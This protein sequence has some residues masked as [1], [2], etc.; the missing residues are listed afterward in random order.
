MK[1]KIRLEARNIIAAVASLELA[2]YPYLAS[3]EAN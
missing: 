2:I 3:P 1:I